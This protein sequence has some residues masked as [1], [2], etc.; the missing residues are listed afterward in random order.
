MGYAEFELNIPE[1]IREKLP[2]YFD[3]LSADPLLLENVV[4]IPLG[5][6][7]AYML[8]YA[9]DLVYIGKTDAEAGFRSRLTRHFHSIQGR[10]NLDAN[11]VGFKAVRVLVFSNFDLETI[12]IDE[13]SK[14]TKRPVWNFSGFGSNDPGHK[15]EGQKSALFDVQYP[16]DIDYVVREMRPGKHDLMQTILALKQQLPYL[17]RFEIEENENFRKGHEE[18]RA[19]TVELPDGVLTARTVLLRILNSLPIGWQ[20]TVLPNR[21]IMYREQRDYDQQLEVIRSK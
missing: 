9:N 21:V 13:Y 17:F 11:L 8:F 16:V 15:R 19:K 7:G 20:V 12:L 3:G 2:D 5:V 6:Q 1:V 10:K 14:R 18:M 4:R